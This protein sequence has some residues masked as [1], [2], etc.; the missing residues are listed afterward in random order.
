MA[1]GPASTHT[2]SRG[3]GG[4]RVAGATA[5]AAPPSHPSSVISRAPA[6][7]TRYGPRQPG[8]LLVTLRSD[9]IAITARS[10]PYLVGGAP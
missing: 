3:V 1:K 6:A 5:A 2:P 9:A 7:T 10:H 4:F 8:S